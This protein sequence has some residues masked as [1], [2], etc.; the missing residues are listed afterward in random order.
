MTQPSTLPAAGRSPGTVAG[1]PSGVVVT[2]AARGLGRAVAQAF[3]DRGASVVGIDLDP[4]VTE[5]LSGL[6]GARR[7]A[8]GVVG[9]VAD[10]AVL[11]EACRLAAD[12]G[13]GLAT[14]VLNAGVTAPGETATFPLE[15]WDRILGINLGAAFVGAQTAYPY[16]QPGSS[17]VMVSSICASLGFGARAAYC[18]SKSGIDGLVRALAVEW[19]PVGVRVNAV[20]PGTIETEMRAS[21]VASGRV[22]DEAYLARIPMNRIGRPSEI[23]DAV[24][25]LASPQASYITGVVLPVDGGWANAGLPAQT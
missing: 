4:A 10:P 12:A 22:S 5:V 2:G 20:A 6:G 24:V 3:A 13:D 8:V 14:V 17:I 7:G 25:Y 16:L 1:R 21:M 23:A 19:G 9:D 18:A 11:D 15:Q